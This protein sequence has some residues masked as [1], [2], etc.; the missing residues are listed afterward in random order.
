MT[1]SMQQN[2]NIDISED[3]INSLAPAVLKNLLQDHSKSTSKK[4]APIFWAT[5]NY[6]HL[7]PDYAYDK[8]IMPELITGKHGKVVQPRVV[9]SKAVQVA[10][11]KEMAE[12][13][14][15]SWVCNKQNNLIDESWFDCKNVFNTEVDGEDGSHSWIPTKKRIQFHKEKDW[16]LYV[17]D[18][19]LEITCGEGP[20]LASRYDTTTGDYIPIEKRIGILDRKLRVVGENTKNEEVW[21]EWA[22]NACKATYGFEWQGDN[23]LLA[24]EALLMTLIDYYKDKFGKNANL[25]PEILE[26][27]AEII[28]W[29][30]WQMDGLK[31]VVPN[32]CKEEEQHELDL[33]GGEIVKKTACEGCAKG[34]NHKHNGVYCK[35]KDWQEIDAR[36]KKMGKVIKF[37]DLLK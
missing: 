35:I 26:R 16:K 21:L 33:F 12:V 10:R 8:P 11:S 20:Y 28:S 9:K 1:E 29:N 17:C 34:D 22:E 15:P 30:I 32:S 14:T 6:K 27:F 24:R 7:G 37:V 3:F 13:F 23:L 19:R 25:N 2:Q 36:T 4:Y 18:N 5:D 31:G